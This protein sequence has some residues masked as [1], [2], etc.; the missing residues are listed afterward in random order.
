MNKGLTLTQADYQR[1]RD[2]V[3]DRSGL[4]FPKSKQQALGRGLAEALEAS[5]CTSLDEYYDLLRTSLSNSPEWD[6][7]VG[8]LTVGETYFLR[9]KGHFGALARHILPEIVAQREHSSR[10]IRIW[11]A[12]CATGEEPYS[13]AI[14]LRELIPNPESWNILILATDINRYALLRAQEGLYGAWSFRGVEKRVQDHYFR[15]DG[16]RYAIGDEIKHMVT[17]DYL[18]LVGDYYPSLSNNT[19]AMDVVL[20][21]NV[22]IYF[23]PE[24]T[25][26]VLRRFYNCLVDGGWLVPG[27]S[28]PNMVFYR[29]F[30]HE[31]FPGAVVYQ[32]PAVTRAKARPA[33]V[34]KPAATVSPS[35]PSVKPPPPAPE[36]P[37]PVR[38]PQAPVTDMTWYQS[39][40]EIFEP[41]ASASE[42][43]PP[44]PEIP[45]PVREPQ[46]PPPD[47]YQLALK[48]LEAGQVD[49]ALVKLYEKLDQDP[50][51]A[52]TY[53]MLG[54]IYANKGNLE[55]AQNWCERAI[56]RNKL[57]PGS[58][59]T[60]SMVYQQHGLPDM[61]LDALKKTIYLDREF[62][63]AHYNLAHLYRQ[64]GQARLARKSFQNVKRLLDGKPWGEPIPEGD[65]MVAGR[66]LQ[67][68]E[69]ELEAST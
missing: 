5:S 63:L 47:P 34:L 65:G 50:E 20:C 14:V 31:N 51:F 21:R 30:Q 8:V 12:G 68:V 2:L 44:A 37:V 62:V 46:A 18:N 3:L 22:T 4:H 48:S 53:Y 26:E 61:A 55:E 36:I 66:L 16:K 54:K 7:L 43:A 17:F 15:F 10:R 45:V 52:P 32:K 57:H 1:F 28:E 39:F 27:A 24:T 13:V 11:S 6:R 60:L 42:P 33:P 69:M 49:D 56:K 40:S 41:P 67:L 64:R 9:N 23:T 35:L 38:E 25:R 29:D 19:N 59:Y 58:Y